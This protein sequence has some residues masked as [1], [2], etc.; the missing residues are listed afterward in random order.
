M[1]LETAEAAF[2]FRFVLDLWVLCF[3]IRISSLYA[4]V[5]VHG[6]YGAVNDVL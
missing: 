3:E 1:S 5:H 4:Y 6:L 2:S